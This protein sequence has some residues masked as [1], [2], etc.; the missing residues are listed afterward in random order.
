LR[1]LQLASRAAFERL[2]GEGDD[3]GL[4]RR[5]LMVLCKT[6]RALEEEGHTA[7]RAR[8]LGIPAE[9]LDARQAAALEPGIT[10]DI[11]GAVYYERDCHLD[12]ARFVAALERRLRSAGVELI[13]DAAVTGWGREGG[14]L[15]A[16]R[17]TRGEI[18]G[19][20]FVLAGG[21][22]SPEL[23]RELGLRLPMQAGKGYSV[24]LPEPVDRPGICAILAEARVA[25]TPMGGALRFGGTMELA[26]MDE[27]INGRR[28]SGIVR[29]AQEYFPRFQA[30]QFAGVK[31]WCGLRPCSPDG[32]PYL[33]RTRV[34]DNLVV[35]TGHA[36]MGLSLAP[37][38][39]EIIGAMLDGEAA[40][41]DLGLMRVDRFG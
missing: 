12:P 14:R 9:V 5:G 24:T 1:D 35:A 7:G 39:G 3:F 15:A 29:A 27:T 33:G 8:V 28:V 32:L 34:A 40:R 17:T 36:M 30:E 4:E 18:E 11:S 22:W 23:V 31:P 2:V 13:Y 20:E 25:V 16:V 26:G 6:A 10:M 37:V 21:A 38:T 19:D 41:F